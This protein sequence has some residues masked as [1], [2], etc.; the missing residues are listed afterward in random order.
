[1]P[2]DAQPQETETIFPRDP[3]K[4]YALAEWVRGTSPMVDKG[5][6]NTVLYHKDPQQWH[7]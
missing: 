1:M 4:T 7:A 6:D 3:N 2:P 5:P